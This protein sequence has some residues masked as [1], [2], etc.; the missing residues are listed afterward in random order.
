VCVANEG[1]TCA[2]KERPSN[3]SL[4]P[5]SG[6]LRGLFPFAAYHSR[7]DFDA[8]VRSWSGT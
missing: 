6:E 2:T 1:D 3:I 7:L 5:F 8:Q 4:F